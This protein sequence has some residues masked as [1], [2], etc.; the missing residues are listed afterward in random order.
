MAIDKEK[1]KEEFE[2]LLRSTKRDGID[3]V[4]EDLEKG[5]FFEAPASAG[6]HLNVEGGLCQHSLNTCKAGLMIY[7]G[8]KTIDASS[9]LSEKA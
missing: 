1:N 2:T 3:Y 4:I 6:H 5:G 7:E 8:L 9:R